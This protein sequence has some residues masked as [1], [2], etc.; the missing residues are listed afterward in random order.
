MIAGNAFLHSSFRVGKTEVIG[1]DVIAQEVYG[2]PHESGND[3]DPDHRCLLHQSAGAAKGAG[4]RGRGTAMATTIS[5]PIGGQIFF[6][7]PRLENPT[8]V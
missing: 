4:D 8:H 3:L 5:P 6:M 2:A 7:P 1:V